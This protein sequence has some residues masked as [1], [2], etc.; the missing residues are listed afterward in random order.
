[1]I[2]PSAMNGY[3]GGN[4]LVLGKEDKL[5]LANYSR[6]VPRAAKESELGGQLGQMYFVVSRECTQVSDQ[7]KK[8]SSLLCREVWADIKHFSA[9]MFAY[10]FSFQ[11]IFV[12]QN[13]KGNSKTG[14]LWHL[15]D[16]RSENAG[17]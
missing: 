15:G 13:L 16:V 9:S 1:M 3:A 4:V 6:K 10:I 17:Q 5:P 14:A 2:C 12:C 8:L 7:W 11:M